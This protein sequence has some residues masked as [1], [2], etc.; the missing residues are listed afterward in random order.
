MSCTPST[1]LLGCNLFFE[2]WGRIKI[3]RWHHIFLL[4]V[5]V[6]DDFH[7]KIELN[8]VILQKQVYNNF[9]R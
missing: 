6:Y 8:H 3:C 4:L 7:C 1:T 9:K 5:E 2:G